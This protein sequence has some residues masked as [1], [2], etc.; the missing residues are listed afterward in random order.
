MCTVGSGIEK[1]VCLFKS[2]ACSLVR[3]FA[4]IVDES[5]WRCEN[6][7]LVMTVVLSLTQVRQWLS[8]SSHCT[9]RPHSGHYPGGEQRFM[10][11]RE[12]SVAVELN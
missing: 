10:D 4:Q 2:H 8:S 12:G 1:Q 3:L 9:T 5:T 11:L 6:N 7:S